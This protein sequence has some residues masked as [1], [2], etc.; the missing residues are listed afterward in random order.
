MRE[1]I[2]LG[3]GVDWGATAFRRMGTTR[4]LA[5][6]RNAILLVPA[7]CGEACVLKTFHSVGKR[8]YPSGLEVESEHVDGIKH[9]ALHFGKV[10]GMKS[11][12]WWDGAGEMR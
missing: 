6:A 1:T 5:L 9:S 8:R 10:F 4:F 11:R 2:L 3:P 7:W 12:R